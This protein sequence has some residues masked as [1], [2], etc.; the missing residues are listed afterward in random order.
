MALQKQPEIVITDFALGE[1]MNGLQAARQIKTY[2][3]KCNIILLTMYDPKEIMRR[4]GDGTI[5]SF[6]S[7]SN[8]Y[9][10]LIPTIKRILSGPNRNS[11]TTT[12]NTRK[13]HD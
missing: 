9:E 7:K 4:D 13:K 2:F 5:K 1:E 8:L 3:P 6:I 11:A 12:I 10:E